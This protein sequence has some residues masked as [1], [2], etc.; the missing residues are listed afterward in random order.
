MNRKN[1]SA[2]DD[3][4]LVKR[5]QNG[6]Q[7]AFSELVK[8]YQKRVYYLAYGMLGNNEDAQDVAQESFIKAF[9][10]L[11]GFRGGGGFYTWLYR[12]AY[13]LSIDFRRKE[14]KKKNVEYEDNI[15]HSDEHGVMAGPSP[16]FHPG[17]D[18]AQKE[19][20]RVIMDAI[21]ELPEQ[22]RA[23]ILLREIEGL[24]YDEIAKTL[25][26]RKGTVM[27]RLHYARQ[28]LQETLLP[29]IEDGEI[30]EKK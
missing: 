30:R 16:A 11:K 19:L 24:S 6:D 28:H 2:A 17:K 13:N 21:Q 14:W 25:K 22:H 23:V 3:L 18:T 27:S 8:R 29:Y 15:N 26:V 12:I 7:E 10:G 9:R 20:S 1:D 4:E 5:S